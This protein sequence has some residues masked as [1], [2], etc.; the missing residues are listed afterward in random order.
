M[1]NLNVKMNAVR[2]V[3][4]FF[5]TNIIFRFL[6]APEKGVKLESKTAVQFAERK[7]D[8][9][10]LPASLFADC[11]FSRHGLKQKMVDSL[12]MN[13]DVKAVTSLK[14]S[15]ESLSTLWAQFMAG[16]FNAV[17]R[18]TAATVKLSDMETQFLASVAAGITT[19]EQASVLYKSITGKELPVPVTESEVSEPDV[20]EELDETDTEENENTEA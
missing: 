2:I 3:V 17:S 6:Q 7:F 5:A 10:Q 18:T 19:F 8:M 1:E 9:A 12:A 4:S 13:K 15:V 14:E 16:N 20:S 11:P